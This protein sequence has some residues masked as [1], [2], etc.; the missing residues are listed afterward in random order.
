MA[1]QGFLSQVE[2]CIHLLK[3]FEVL[4]R[5]VEQRV[6]GSYSP[7]LFSKIIIIMLK[8]LHFITLALK[9]PAEAC[10]LVYFYHKIPTWN[11]AQPSLGTN[12][13]TLS[14][15]KLLNKC[16]NAV[17]PFQFMFKFNLREYSTNCKGCP[18]LF[19]C[20]KMTVQPIV[21]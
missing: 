20:N 8:Q 11:S 16:L 15:M 3:K 1:L 17:F 7:L 14:V 6:A 2:R 12:A 21:E 18:H 9:Y 13:P 4:T 10:K 19:I 5:K